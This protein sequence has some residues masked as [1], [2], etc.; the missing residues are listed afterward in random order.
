[1]YKS[2]EEHR[3]RENLK[4]V[5]GDYKNLTFSVVSGDKKKQIDQAIGDLLLNFDKYSK[6]EINDKINLI[7]QDITSCR[8]QQN[9]D[10][11]H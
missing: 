11:K 8:N 3:L 10:S 6:K 2:Y 4:A 1:M 9:I 5:V 7:K